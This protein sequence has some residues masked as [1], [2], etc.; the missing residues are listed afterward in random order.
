MS[1]TNIVMSELLFT[2]VTP[3]RRTSS[4]SLLRACATRFCTFTCARSGS[5]PVLNVM[6]RLIDPVEVDC[7][8]M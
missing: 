2:V 6:V 7:E 3:M 8:A 4:G 5:V 1:C